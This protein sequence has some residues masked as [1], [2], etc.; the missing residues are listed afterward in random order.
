MKTFI[1]FGYAAFVAFLSLRPMNSSSIEPW[2]KPFHFVLYGIF[3][4]LGYRLLQTQRQYLY[5]CV[6]IVAFSGLMEVLQS[7]MPG[8]V[9]SV[10]DLLANT[11]GVTLGA[12]LASKLQRPSVIQAVD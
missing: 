5:L 9:M 1:F 4:W 2:D 8:R 12:L 11:L 10:Y 6:G 7:F 3:A